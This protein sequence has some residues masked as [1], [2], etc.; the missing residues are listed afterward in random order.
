MTTGTT[1]HIKYIGSK[2][3]ELNIS[4]NLTLTQ[5][6]EKFL[7]EYTTSQKAQKDINES[8]N[9][10]NNSRN[11]AL[12]ENITTNKGKIV[13]TNEQPTKRKLKHTRICNFAIKAK[14]CYWLYYHNTNSMV[15]R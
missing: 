12:D 13:K 7:H 11:I 2:F 8:I 9:I 10:P 4:D 6:L 5:V 14:S 15:Y 1:D 3:D